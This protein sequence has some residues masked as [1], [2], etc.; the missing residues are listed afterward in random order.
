M[1]GIPK[2]SFNAINLSQ[3]E[4]TGSRLQP[5]AKRDF[6][7]A[8]LCVGPRVN[9]VETEFGNEEKC[10]FL[11]SLISFKISRIWVMLRLSCS[12]LE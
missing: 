1:E 2:Q 4:H 3:G 9:G 10:Y 5:L 12:D 7:G 8:Y 11:D 6:V